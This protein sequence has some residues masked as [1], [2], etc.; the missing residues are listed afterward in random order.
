M[1]VLDQIFSEIE[2]RIE[3]VLLSHL[4][5]LGWCVML[6][7]RCQTKNAQEE[8]LEADLDGVFSAILEAGLE[9]M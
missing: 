3:G 1:H 2:A 7:F 8:H 5:E 4:D 6:F 9:E